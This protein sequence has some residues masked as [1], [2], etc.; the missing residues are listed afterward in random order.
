MF[1]A[2][3]LSIARSD[4][5]VNLLGR[6]RLGRLTAVLNDFSL[7]NILSH[8]AVMDFTFLGDFYNQHCVN[9]HLNA[10]EPANC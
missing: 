4:T 6:P 10:R 8:S 7:V 9:T 1:F 3:S 5:G 2:F